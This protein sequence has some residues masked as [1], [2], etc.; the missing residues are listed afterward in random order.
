MLRR[1]KTHRIL[2]LA[3]APL[4]AARLAGAADDVAFFNFGVIAQKHRAHLI[5]F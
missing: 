1:V 4:L 5:L 2:G 3:L